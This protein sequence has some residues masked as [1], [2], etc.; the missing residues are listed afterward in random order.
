[1]PFVVNKSMV[2]VVSDR[3]LIAVAGDE[4]RHFTMSKD[5]LAHCQR[6]R[7]FWS[8]E[9]ISVVN[10]ETADS[11][12]WA[13]YKADSPMAMR[14]CQVNE[15][16][17]VAR[18]WRISSNEVVFW[19]PV[20]DTVK[21]S[22]EGR[23]VKTKDF[24][25]LRAVRLDRGC[26]AENAN[27]QMMTP[28]VLYKETMVLEK[29]PVA[30]N[31]S[32]FTHFGEAAQ[33]NGLSRTV[34]DPGFPKIP[35]PELPYPSLPSHP[36]MHWIGL[37]VAMVAVLVAGGVVMYGMRHRWMRSGAKEALDEVSKKSSA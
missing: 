18:V 21:I 25:G 2:E 10:K 33:G 4:K 15:M 5:E 32:A 17:D 27:F 19:Q 24:K 37:V 13:L 22:C 23:V 35:D 14:T 26:W 28:S 29:A 30:L 1:V 12:L 36:A 6:F 7:G 9:E 16:G 34:H 31:L 20:A 11:C 8:C 3:Q